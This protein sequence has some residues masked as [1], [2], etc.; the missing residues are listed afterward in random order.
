MFNNG[1]NFLAMMTVIPVQLIMR[2]IRRYTE[3][4]HFI[5]LF[6][7]IMIGFAFRNSC[8]L[9]NALLC[10]V[11]GCKTGKL[12]IRIFVPW[13]R[14]VS[15]SRHSCIIKFRHKNLATVLVIIKIPG[16][17]AAAEDILK[18]TCICVFVYVFICLSHI[19]WPH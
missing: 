2:N 19:S 9:N 15:W 13:Y 3:I 8:S 18:F 6:C 11:V 14:A 17:R 16:G 10:D 12:N 5:I 7:I 4:I 1:L